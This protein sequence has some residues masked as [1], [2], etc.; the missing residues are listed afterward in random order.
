M[1]LNAFYK[2]ALQMYIHNDEIGVD[3]THPYDEIG[4]NITNIFIYDEMLMTIVN[5]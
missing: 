5:I 3:I 1:A 4:L 2:T